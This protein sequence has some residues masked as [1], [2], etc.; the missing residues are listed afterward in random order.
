LKKINKLCFQKHA[1][2]K[3]YD[4]WQK[5]VEQE[6]LVPSVPVDDQTTIVEFDEQ[7]S[8]YTAATFDELCFLGA[9]LMEVDFAAVV[10]NQGNISR[11]IAG[12]GLKIVMRAVDWEFNTAP[13]NET[14]NYVL[15]DAQ[16]NTYV[17][18]IAREFGIVSIGS[19]IRIALDAQDTHSLSLLL[20]G[21]KPI[22]KPSARKFQLISEIGA[23]VKEQ[24]KTTVES[25]IDPESDVT[26]AKSLDQVKD[27]IKQSTTA[28]F[29]LDSRFTIIAANKPAAQLSRQS[30]QKMN[31]MTHRDFSPHTA[32]AVHFLYEYA[33]KTMVTPPEFEVIIESE[34]PRIFRI[35]V[36]PFSPT[37]TRDY[38]LLVHVEETTHLSARANTLSATIRKENPI[39]LP[40]DPSQLFL[41]ETLVR[42]RTI[43]QRKQ[44][45]FVVLR[46]W[47]QIIKPYQI[48]ALKALKQNIPP[49]FAHEIAK[50]ITAEVESLFGITG[51]KAIVPMPCGHSKGASCLSVEIARALSQISGLPVIQAFISEPLKGVSHP[52]ENAKRPP[53]RMTRII[54]EPVLLIDDVVTSGAHIEEAVALLKPTC[55]AVLPIAWLGGDVAE[56]SEE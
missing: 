23:L 12:H 20:F 6:R 1:V 47:R 43:R 26:V 51:F 15:P 38:F 13:Y 30:V 2:S 45:S 31:G 4:I 41:L 54:T 49:T 9:R 27:I 39:V 55:G 18:R 8:P 11:L 53:M 35:N 42:R 56:K 34:I 28:M 48:T 19:F 21:S 25:L 40:Q 3:G 36:T 44:T 22:Q 46:A 10:L 16:N 52:K 50:E 37:D 7:S 29:L 17:Q 32:D 5:F 33:L 14:E 24:Y